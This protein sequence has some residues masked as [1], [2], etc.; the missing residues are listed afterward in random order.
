M[1]GFI[2]LR[3]EVIFFQLSATQS[4]RSQLNIMLSRKKKHNYILIYVLPLAITPLL[5]KFA[6]NA[7]TKRFPFQQNFIDA[8]RKATSLKTEID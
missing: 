2:V 1:V 4:F 6:N 7:L 8:Q 5:N 3:P